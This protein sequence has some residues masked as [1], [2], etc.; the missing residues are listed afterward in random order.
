[1]CRSINSSKLRRFGYKLFHRM[2]GGKNATLQQHTEGT[3]KY[4][5][6]SEHDQTKKKEGRPR[7]I[8]GRCYRVE[9]VTNQQRKQRCTG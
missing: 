6:K 2:A 5:S 4:H 1:M 3:G 7:E 8:C 9:L